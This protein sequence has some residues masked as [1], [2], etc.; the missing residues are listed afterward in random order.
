MHIVLFSAS[1]LKDGEGGASGSGQKCIIF[2]KQSDFYFNRAVDFMTKG[3]GMKQGGNMM[4]AN[5]Y[6]EYASA[7]AQNV[8]KFAPEPGCL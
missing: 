5:T 7:N 6:Y 3:D 2:V 4:V 1:D 8:L